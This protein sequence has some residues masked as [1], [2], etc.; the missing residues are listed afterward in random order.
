ML[1]GHLIYMYYLRAGNN[2]GSSIEISQLTLAQISQLLR[3]R[4]ALC[5]PEHGGGSRLIRIL[6]K[7]FQSQGPQV[8]RMAYID[9]TMFTFLFC[10]IQNG[11]SWLCS[12]T[13]VKDDALTP[14]Q[15]TT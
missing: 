8:Q 4:L 11:S 6:G 5:E 15:I 3:A 14:Q 7:W 1:H 10:F 12:V 13:R 9:W 2:Y